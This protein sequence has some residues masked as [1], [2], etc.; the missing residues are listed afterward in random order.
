MSLRAMAPGPMSVAGS[1]GFESP[2]RTDPR[3]THPACRGTWRS[4][5]VCPDERSTALPDPIT[6][7]PSPNRPLHVSGGIGLSNSRCEAVATEAQFW[8]CRCGGSNNKPFCHGTHKK[9][10]F[11]SARQ[12]DPVQRGSQAHAGTHI[13]VRDY[14]PVCAR[15][16]HCTEHSPSVFSM[17]AK[18]WIDADA[19][20]VVKTVA[21][22]RMCPS[23]AM[24][25]SI[26]GVPHERSG[27]GP[28][29]RIT[30]DRPYALVGGPQL[31]GEA[32]RLFQ[33]G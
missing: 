5:T 4:K 27:R 9:L 11:S 13:A 22:I 30:K 6:I 24:A 19:D 12:S 17:T 7:D 21:T 33:Y 3:L 18:P 23:R 20:A 10:G 14:R 28:S 25:Y 2:S 26:D 31:K 1:L 29:V 32:V 16:G 15:A 8:L